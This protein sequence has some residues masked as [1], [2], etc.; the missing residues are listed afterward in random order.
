MVL[1]QFELTK[2]MCQTVFKLGTYSLTFHK[3]G[4]SNTPPAWV[5]SLKATHMEEEGLGEKERTK[6][7]Y[8]VIKDSA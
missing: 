4:G 2:P 3:D 1:P 7:F 8:V 6:N 5:E